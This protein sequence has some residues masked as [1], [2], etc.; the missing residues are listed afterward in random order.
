MLILSVTWIRKS[1]SIPAYVSL[2]AVCSNAGGSLSSPCFVTWP[3][4]F[5]SPLAM[6]ETAAYASTSPCPYPWLGDVGYALSVNCSSCIRS[7][8]VPFLR[9]R[10]WRSLVVA[11]QP[12]LKQQGQPWMFHSIRLH[13]RCPVLKNGY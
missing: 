3:S 4:S 6:D 11:M 1:K 2:G 7:G 12:L 10:Y 9:Q 8:L 13:S 5:P